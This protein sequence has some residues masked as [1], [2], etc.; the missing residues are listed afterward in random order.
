MKNKYIMILTAVMAVV[1]FS[2]REAHAWVYATTTLGPAADAFINQ[3][4]LPY[5]HQAKLVK[6]FANANAYSSPIATQRGYQGFDKFSITVGTMAAAQVPT[7]TTDLSYYKELSDELRKQG[8]VYVGV[9]WNCW[10]VNVGV[11]LPADFTLSAKFG[12]LK[13]TYEEYDFDNIIAG[14]MLNYQIVQPKSPAVKFVLWRG[15]SI[16]TG[17]TWQ[18]S[19]TTLRFKS[20]TVSDGTN[21]AKPKLNMYIK[22]ET[23]VVPLEISTAVRLFWVLNIHVGGGV[24]FAFGSSSIEYSSAGAMSSGGNVGYY[25]VYGKQNG[26]GPTL[27]LPKVFCGP[28][29]NFGPVIIDMPFTYYFNNGFDLGVTFGIVW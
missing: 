2:M 8:D 4:L 22:T 1:I 10:A 15:L 27:V 11:K 20:F 17:L 9:G 12:M 21:L 19:N 18:R 23:F 28:G 16:G 7:T 13:Y 26:T 29:L 14:G 25:T 3:A 5:Q 24:D 6:G